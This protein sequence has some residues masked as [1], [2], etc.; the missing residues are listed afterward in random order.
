MK[1]EQKSN[2]VA[3]PGER[4]VVRILTIHLKA[5][6]WHAIYR[7]EKT[8]EYRIANDYW[9]RR[10]RRAPYDEIHLCL[11]YPK[12]GDESK[13]LRRKW[14]WHPPKKR[15]THPHFGCDPVMVYAIDVSQPIA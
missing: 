14:V 7:G 15:I 10:L 4:R 8:E 12:R 11:G 1:N 6:Y 3:G 2:A 5:E 13:I 9:E